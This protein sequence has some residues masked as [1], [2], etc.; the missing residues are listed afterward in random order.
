MNWARWEAAE[1]CTTGA[2]PGAR[3]LLAWCLAE[4]PVAWSGGIFNCRTVR[5]TQV[6]S[7]HGEGRALDVMLPTPNGRAHPD[8][9]DLLRR[10]GANGRR[11]G[12]QAIIF[13]RVIYSARSPEGRPYTGVHPH[14]DHLHIELTRQ[15]GATLTTAQIEA[16]LG[17]SATRPAEVALGRVLR[18]R[19]PMMRGEDVREVQRRLNIK[20]DGIFGPQTDGAVRQFQRTRGLVVD[21]IVGPITWAELTA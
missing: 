4:Y 19:R 15:A 7:I 9:Y 13:D 5:G 10:L 16:A 3:L 11:L 12:L 21:G 18:L 1:R 8:G 17:A 2:A 20:A 6:R 14:V